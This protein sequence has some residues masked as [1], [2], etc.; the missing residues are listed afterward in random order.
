[1]FLAYA[2]ARLSTSA[3]RSAPSGC[4][5][6]AVAELYCPFAGEGA[7]YRCQRARCA[8]AVAVRRPEGTVWTCGMV[9]RGVG[10]RVIIA[11]GDGPHETITD[12]NGGDPWPA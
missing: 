9:S 8:A 12:Q 5:V 3:A 1:M 2:G 4:G 7:D 11:R 6:V 10:D